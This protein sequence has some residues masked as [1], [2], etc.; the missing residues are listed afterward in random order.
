MGIL[1]LRADEGVAN[2][3]FSA[4][5]PSVF[6]MDGRII[7]VPLSQPKKQRKNWKIAGA[8]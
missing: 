1:A 8:R 2:V 5:W 4:D 6:L 7:S 3:D